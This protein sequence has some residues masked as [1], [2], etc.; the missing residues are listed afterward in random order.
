MQKRSYIAVCGAVILWGSTFAVFKA[1]I[2]S[3][4]SFDIIA[5]R[6]IIAT[7]CLGLL[8]LIFPKTRPR[9]PSLRGLLLVALM[10]FFE[11][12]LYFIFEGMA[13]RH[14]SAGQ[15]GM[16]TALLPVTTV[17]AARI[18]LKEDLTVIRSIGILA[19][20]GGVVL[21]TLSGESSL[22]APRPILGNL[23]EVAAM[24]SATFY[25][26]LSRRMSRDFSPL[27]LSFVMSLLGSI[28]FVPGMLIR[29]SGLP[30]MNS[31]TLMGYG[32]AL[33]LGV[34]ASFL[35]YLLYNYALKHLKAGETA[36]FIN[37]MPPVALIIS[38]LSGLESPLNYWQWMSCA[39]ILLGALLA[40]REKKTGE[41]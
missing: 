13:L 33:Y 15:A 1:G 25:T 29:H 11:P 41:V 10:A 21:L 8:L 9:S 34:A 19:T 28:A 39:V 7:V 37:F 12:V 26:I 22:G 31:K 35:G 32:I 18:F 27:F 30:P 23:L 17:I 2:T 5:L 14:T 24:V 3:L 38:Q 40:Q 6:H 16:I 36:V 4:P 20:A